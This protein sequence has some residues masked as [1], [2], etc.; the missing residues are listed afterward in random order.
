MWGGAMMF[1][2]REGICAPASSQPGTNG[3]WRSPDNF[4]RICLDAI[5]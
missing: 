5:A 2:E 1:A 3:L 4:L